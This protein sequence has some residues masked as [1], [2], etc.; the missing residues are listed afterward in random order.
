MF[1]CAIR[2]GSLVHCGNEVLKVM[3]NPNCSYGL[4]NCLRTSFAKKR[5]EHSFVSYDHHFALSSSIMLM[6]E[7]IA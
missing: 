1:L 3:V 7:S 2:G 6:A 5:E 4:A